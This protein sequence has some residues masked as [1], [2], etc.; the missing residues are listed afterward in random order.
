MIEN[1]G[2][3]SDECNRVWLLKTHLR[4]IHRKSELPER[5]VPHRIAHVCTNVWLS[6]TTGAVAS[7]FSSVI[8]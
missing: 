8:I 7:P 6:L 1:W 4:E 3:G 2:N 5:T